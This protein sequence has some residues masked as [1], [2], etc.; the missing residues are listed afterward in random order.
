MPTFFAMIVA[1]LAAYLVG[2][3]IKA[4]LAGPGAILL[5]VIWVLVYYLVRKWLIKLKP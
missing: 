2:R 3:P 5:L 1:S 4:Y